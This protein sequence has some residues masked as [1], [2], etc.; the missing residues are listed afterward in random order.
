LVA[1]WFG[2]IAEK[3]Q[4]KAVNDCRC[5]LV[6]RDSVSPGEEC[7]VRLQPLVPEM[8]APLVGIGLEIEFWEGHPI[9]YGHITTIL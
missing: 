9:S 1:V 3:F 2:A 4:T 6:D 5:F 8:V 7:D